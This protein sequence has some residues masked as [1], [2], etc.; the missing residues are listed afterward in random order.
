M[1][2][3]V[4]SRHQKPLKR[5]MIYI[6]TYTWIEGNSAFQVD[7][8]LQGNT[9]NTSIPIETKN[10]QTHEEWMQLYRDILGDIP[11]RISDEVTPSP[12]RWHSQSEESRSVFALLIA[13]GF[14]VF[15]S[16]ISRTTSYSHTWQHHCINHLH[17][18]V[19]TTSDQTSLQKLRS[20]IV[21]KSCL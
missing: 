8:L 10:S 14:L 1:H 9:S 12:Q 4:I 21:S 18:F 13:S 11:K 3:P 17:C 20:L 19:C 15:P 7:W 2:K 6:C 16:T 5:Y